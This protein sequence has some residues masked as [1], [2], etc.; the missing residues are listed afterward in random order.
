M[1]QVW[2]DDR[3]PRQT[4]AMREIALSV[5]GWLSEGLG[6]VIARVFAVEGFGSRRAGEAL[7]VCGAER[8]GE[9][10]GASGAAA[11]DEAVA[12]VLASG[13]AVVRSMSIGD[14]DAV[15]AGLT[16]GGTAHVIVQPAGSMP[17]SVWM[18]IAC[19]VPVVLATVV[20]GDELGASLAVCLD[21]SSDGSVGEPVAD[22]AVRAAAADMLSHGRVAAQIVD[23]TV[24]RVYLE[25]VL[26]VPAA[27]V[28]GAGTLAEAIAAQALL[29]GWTTTVVDERKVDGWD[30]VEGA[31]ALGPVDALIVLSHDI[32]VSAAAL[33]AALTG[34]CGYVGA[35]GSR[36]TQAARAA[37]LRS[38]F[39]ADDSL[40]GRIHGP[41]GLDLGSRSPEE[42]ALAIFAEVLGARSG[43]TAGS[44]R[45]GTGPI[46]G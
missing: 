46:N 18:S 26:P 16:C 12:S 45:A 17:A 33:Y 34:A 5:S 29:L 11:I 38:A 31:K 44:L 9:L 3:R 10:L 15:D 24:G 36:K 42:T 40:I 23:A 27:Y 7:A 25:S 1:V 4:A 28:V 14:Q 6:V 32:E 30:V 35:L 22:E 43:R 21:G 39:D 41:I 2:A 37:Q 13:K 8:S 20:D 19:R